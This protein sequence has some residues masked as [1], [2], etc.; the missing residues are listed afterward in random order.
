[1][2]QLLAASLSFPSVVFTALLGVVL[3]YWLLV[4]AGAAGVDLFG[5]GAAD[6][7]EAGAIEA[8]GKGAAEGA[9]GG[10]GGDVG[11]GGL[12]HGGGEGGWLEA[13][14]LRSAPA[15]VVVSLWVTFSWLACVVA[16]EALASWRGGG[17]ARWAVEALLLLAAPAAALPVTSLAVRPLA[18][19]FVPRPAA[20]ARR[21]FIGKV[22]T[23]RTGTVDESF[24]EAVLGERGAEVVLRVRVDGAPALKRGE[25]ALVVA[26]DEAN[27]AFTVAPFDELVGPAPGAGPARPG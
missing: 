9:L 5:D 19:V 13:L 21:D 18:G 6:G 3:L 4:V 15:T 2:A 12:G 22:C 20:R 25:R 11:D 26:F 10:G 17:A 7:V 1:M 27:D 23:V 14:H 16:S 24:G 8:A